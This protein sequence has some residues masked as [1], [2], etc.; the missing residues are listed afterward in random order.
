M[1]VCMYIMCSHSLFA[2]NIPMLTKS[3][4]NRVTTKRFQALFSSC[5]MS[6]QLEAFR[7]PSENAHWQSEIVPGSSLVVED[8]TGTVVSKENS[9]MSFFVDENGEVG[10]TNT[11]HLHVQHVFL[12]VFHM[13]VRFIW[14]I[15]GYGS[16]LGT[17]IIGW[18]ILN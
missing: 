12:C 18:L 7:N 3:P 13:C 8:N 11:F 17:P 4:Q 6:K 5:H 2:V 10:S 15:N 14:R 16:K 9:S 1:Y